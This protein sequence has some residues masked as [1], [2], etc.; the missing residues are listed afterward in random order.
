MITDNLISIFTDKKFYIV[1][2]IITIVI[3]IQGMIKHKIGD[4]M[5]TNILTM[6]NTT[7]NLWS[8]SHLILYMYFGYMFPNMFIEFLIIGI[9]WEGIE[10]VFPLIVTDYK[11][12]FCQ[13][14]HRIDCKIVCQISP[15]NYWYGRFSDIVA[16]SAGFIIGMMLRA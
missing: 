16:N 1:I 2:I 15:P 9:I 8:L 12:Q 14:N 6:C 5:A 10:A 4:P 11:T 7:F 3:F 13:N